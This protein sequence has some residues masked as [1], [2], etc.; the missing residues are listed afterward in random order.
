VDKDFENRAVGYYKMCPKPRDL[1]TENK[2]T[3]DNFNQN[4]CYPRYDPH[5]ITSR[6]IWIIAL[7]GA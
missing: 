1:P 2:K 4:V 6:Y 7:Y 5:Q 3:A